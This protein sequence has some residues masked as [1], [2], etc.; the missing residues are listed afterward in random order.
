MPVP[1]ASSLTRKIG[2]D[3]VRY[4][5]K[6]Q[7]IACDVVWAEV[8]GFFPNSHAA[9]E[10]MKQ[11]GIVFGPMSQ[12]TATTAGAIWKSYRS[13]GGRHQRAA[14]DFLIGAHA[15]V[16]ADQLL[17]RDRGFYRTYFSRLKILDL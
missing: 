9:E 5:A 1:R 14:A 13:Q 3:N 6:G 12:E 11:L 2:C 16:Q 17:T 15:L 7:L 8:S 4:L 10:A